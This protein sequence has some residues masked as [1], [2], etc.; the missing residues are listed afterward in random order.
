MELNILDIAPVITNTDT[1]IQFLRGRNLLLQDYLCCNNPCSKVKDL[2]ISDNQIFQCKSCRRRYSI[3]TRSFW[4]KSKLQLTVLVSLMFFFSKGSSVKQTVQMLCG[5]VTR[6]SIITWFNFFRDIMTCYFVNNPVIFDNTT[7]HIDETFIGGKRKYNRGRIPAVRTRYL[8][9]IVDKNSHKCY[10]EFVTKRDFINIIPLITHVR[11][12]CTINTDGA[13]VY[14]MLD[15]MR[16]THN[17]V[18][19]KDHFC[20]PCNTTTHKLDRRF[21]GKFEN[22]TQKFAWKPRPNA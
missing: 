14:N 19:H 4:E 7:V 20:Q 15:Q 13:R 5:K 8:V 6:F 16:F 11:P 1:C 21:L 22:K 3:R 2:K 9:G 18:I 17:V 12:G 10:I